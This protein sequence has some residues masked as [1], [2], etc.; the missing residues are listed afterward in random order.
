[1]ALEFRPS[2]GPDASPTSLDVV[3]TSENLMVRAYTIA[4]I[5]WGNSVRPDVVFNVDIV[6]LVELEEIVERLARCAAGDE[7]AAPKL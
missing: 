4:R 6:T 3:R 2:Q 1:M 7:G 5:Q